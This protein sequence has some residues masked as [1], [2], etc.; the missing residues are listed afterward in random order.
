[1]VLFTIIS[2]LY[3]HELSKNL[4]RNCLWKGLELTEIA[5]NDFIGIDAVWNLIKMA[6]VIFT[7]RN[8]RLRWKCNGL[9]LFHY[10]FHFKNKVSQ[11]SCK[12][13][14]PSSHRIQSFL[15]IC[16][17]SSNDGLLH[18]MILLFKCHPFKL[19]LQWSCTLISSQCICSVHNVPLMNI[20][21][22]CAVDRCE[23]DMTAID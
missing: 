6:G 17:E 22:T 23:N 12:I 9:I 11:I 4:K 2:R 7:I 1:M 16:T 18:I 14:T 5:P 3:S 20:R 21:S 19:H 8:H 10:W 15:L 13:M